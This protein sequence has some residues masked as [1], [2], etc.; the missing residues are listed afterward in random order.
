[1]SSP[2]MSQREGGTL[3]GVDSPK[4]APPKPTPARIAIAENLRKMMDEYVTETGQEGISPR[5][6]EALAPWVSYKTVQRLLNPYHPMS[7]KLE[8]LDDVAWFFGVDT[9]KLMVR[10]RISIGGTEGRVLE[11]HAAAMGGEGKKKR[12]AR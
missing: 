7:P 8:S 11:T 1:M 9:F 3:K 4:K 5:E 12:T 2:E 10:R 6:L